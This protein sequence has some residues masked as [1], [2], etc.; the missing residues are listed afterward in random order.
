MT[1]YVSFDL[2]SKKLFFK[3]CHVVV[4]LMEIVEFVLRSGSRRLRS[5][6]GFLCFFLLIIHIQGINIGKMTDSLLKPAF[7][8]AV[9]IGKAGLSRRQDRAAAGF[10]DDIKSKAVLVQ[11]EIH[12]LDLLIQRIPVADA[13]CPQ[14]RKIIF[15]IEIGLFLGLT[16]CG[17][18]LLGPGTIPLS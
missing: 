15:V 5:G 3:L 16:D 17:D 1:Q 14:D 11:P 6:L 10:C 9:R 18:L 8:D 13:E 2:F 7:Q 4:S 12:I